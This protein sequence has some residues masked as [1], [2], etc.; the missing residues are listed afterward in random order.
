MRATF[1]AG[2]DKW[3]V[4]ETD[5]AIHVMPCTPEGLAVEPHFADAECSCEPSVE[6][7][8]VTCAR[9]VYNHRCI[10]KH[11]GGCDCGETPNYKSRATAGRGDDAL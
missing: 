6:P 11:T 10:G 3:G 7:D 5:T 2:G 1:T 4:F 9:M 8:T